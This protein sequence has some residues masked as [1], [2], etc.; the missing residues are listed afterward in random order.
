M[1]NV[2]VTGGANAAMY[3]GG[4]ADVIRGGGSSS[5]R[6]PGWALIIT[7]VYHAEAIVN[8]VHRLVHFL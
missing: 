5:E 6:Q 1:G 2:A 4:T 3:E 8:K 7:Y